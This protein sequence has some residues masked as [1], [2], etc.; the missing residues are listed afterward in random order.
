M[1]HT[2]DTTT[3]C[4]SIRSHFTN[5]GKLL[6]ASDYDYFLNKT[7]LKI[8]FH[9]YQFIL[10]VP[11]TFDDYTF[12][13]HIQR[14][15]SKA[16]TIDWI[17]NP[18]LSQQHLLITSAIAPLNIKIQI[19][20]ID[21]FCENILKKIYIPESI[22]NAPNT[23]LDLRYFS[24]SIRF[25]KKTADWGVG[26]LLLLATYPLW[27]LAY[28]K[29]KSQSPGPAFYRQKRVGIRNH[30]FE[31]VK[32][33]SMRLDAEAN[34][35]QFSSKNDDRIF[36]F[37]RTMRSTRIDELPQLLNIVK[38][39]MSLIGPRPERK[40][41][42]DAFEENIPHYAKRHIVK[43]GIS[44]YAQVMYPYGAGIA[45][46]RHKLMYDLYYIKNWSLVLETQIAIKTF[47]TMVAKR[48]M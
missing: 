2:T 42:T 21:S 5:N 41:F 31:C 28:F 15:I 8:L 33:R 46:A 1:N 38:G 4:H 29:I 22:E 48:G 10:L 25:I 27:V 14:L 7:D 36:D 26:A 11:T 6:L 18:E 17:H 40:I 35:A 45:D 24:I 13:A 20:S 47:W 44:G 37:G 3:Y 9:Q 19:Q 43:P 16:K 34:G 12:D 32:F 30:E 39:E 23:D